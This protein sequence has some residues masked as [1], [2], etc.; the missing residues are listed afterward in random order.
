[1]AKPTQS[2]V[3][4]V[5]GTKNAERKLDIVFVHGLGGDA[6]STWRIGEDQEK[7][8]PR[9]LAEDFNNVGVWTIGYGATASRWVEDVMSMEDRS[10]NLIN[11]LFGKGIGER[12]IIFVTHSMGGLITK[13]ILTHA[14]QSNNPKEKQIATNCAGVVFIAVPHV[15]SGLANI[16]DFT[17]V[18]VRGNKIVKQ[19]QKDESSLRALSNRFVEYTK[20]QS[21]SCVSFYETKE[22]RIPKRK[23]WTLGLRVRFGL[24]VVSESS[25]SGRF[26]Q[27]TPIPLDAHPLVREYF[28]KQLQNQKS[29]AWQ[30]VRQQLYEFYKAVPEKEEPDTLNDME[31][32]FAAIVH[33]CGAGLHQQAWD[34]VN[35]PRILRGNDHYVT[36]KLGAFGSNLSALSQFFD[37]AWHTHQRPNCPQIPRHSFLAGP[38]LPCGRWVVCVRQWSRC[39]L[40]WKCISNRK[41]G[42]MPQSQPA[43]SANS[44]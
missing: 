34:E 31:P 41:A 32:L 23:W 39:R 43:T 17:R 38:L 2:Q 33:G 1:M 3:F 16:L 37:Q 44:I 21:L 4:P 24:Q 30:R 10:V 19:L 7:F 5:G 15:G 14:D 18:F 22:V 27:P 13:Y 35:S 8:W 20:R 26:S 12:P 11:R 40:Q 6:H 28:G 29:E 25:A 9:W 36:N 42:N